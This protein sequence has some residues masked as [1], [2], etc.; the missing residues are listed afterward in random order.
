MK[1][2]FRR[3]SVEVNFEGEMKEI[4]VHKELANFAKMKTTDIG[5]ED[6]CRE[7]YHNGEI[8]VTE[9]YAK[10]IKAIISLPDC[11]FYAYVKRGILNAL[12]IQEDGNNQ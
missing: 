3:I 9:Q 7:I 6:F 12:N 10:V 8:E 11:Y 1:I 5:F 4:D 2:D